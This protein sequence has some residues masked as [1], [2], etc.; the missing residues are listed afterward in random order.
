M[1]VWPP[2]AIAVAVGPALTRRWRGSH[3][4]KRRIDVR[5]GTPDVIDLVAVALMAR[6]TRGWLSPPGPAR[7]SSVRRRLCRSSIDSFAGRGW[8]ARGR[9]SSTS[10]A[11]GRH[12]RRRWPASAGVPLGPALDLLASRL[13]TLGGAMPGR[14]PAPARAPRLSADAGILPAFVLLTVVPFSGR[15]STSSPL[16]HRR[17][18]PPYNSRGT[19]MTNLLVRIHAYLLSRA[20]LDDRGQATTEYALVLLGAALVA[21]LLITWATSGG[22][23]GRIGRLLDSVMDAITGKIS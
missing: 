16:R 9:H 10:W 13:V 8:P 21:L 15:R 23:A 22:G 20:Q 18:P 11:T 2:L 4:V 6:L 17:H 1:L 3:A 19:T 14:R 5:P 12:S 7:S